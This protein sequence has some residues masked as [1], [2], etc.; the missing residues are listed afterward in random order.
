MGCLFQ[1]LFGLCEFT[2][3]EEAK[4]EVLGAY[5]SRAIK[6]NVQYVIEEIANEVLG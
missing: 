6:P 1:I 4:Y 2:S 5:P 3:A